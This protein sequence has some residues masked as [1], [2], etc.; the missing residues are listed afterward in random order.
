MDASFADLTSTVHRESGD[1]VDCGI[2]RKWE[3][4]DTEVCDDASSRGFSA[5]ITVRHLVNKED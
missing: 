5:R 1:H 2:A 3:R 4:D